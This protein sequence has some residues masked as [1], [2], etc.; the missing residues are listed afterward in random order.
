[1]DYNI[2]IYSI[3]WDNRRAKT[4]AVFCKIN[5][6]TS[7]WRDV[8]WLMQIPLSDGSKMFWRDGTHC[9]DILS[10]WENSQNLMN[11]EDNL[12]VWEIR[13]KITR[14]N[15]P[16]VNLHCTKVSV[17]HLYVGDYCLKVDIMS[18]DPPTFFFLLIR[19]DPPH[20]HTV[21]LTIL[22]DPFIPQSFFKLF[23]R[24]GH[25]WESKRT[26]FVILLGLSQTNK[27]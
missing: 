19:W 12:R 5:D 17:N 1:M 16:F 14:V 8:Y 26:L 10:A 21:L 3:L 9:S 25:F 6:G 7:R 4:M 20:P 23:C 18:W 11:F 15:T 24:K 22:H 13:S 27:R 2:Q